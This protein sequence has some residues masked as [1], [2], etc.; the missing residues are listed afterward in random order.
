MK[1]YEILSFEVVNNTIEVVFI[2]RNTALILMSSPPQSLPDKVW[3]EIYVCESGRITLHNIIE[4]TVTPQKVISESI[5]F[6]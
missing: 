1:D 5:S 4:G 6:D 3:K 2:Q